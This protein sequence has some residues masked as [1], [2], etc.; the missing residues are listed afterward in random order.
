M[1]LSFLIWFTGTDCFDGC[2]LV[3]ESTTIPCRYCISVLY[4]GVVSHILVAVS[5]DGAFYLGDLKQT[6]YDITD[7]LEHYMVCEFFFVL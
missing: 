5:K 3:R 1:T 7:L 6:F 4:G 2:F